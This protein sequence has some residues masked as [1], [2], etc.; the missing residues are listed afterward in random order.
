MG[1][2]L[3]TAAA[4]DQHA[5]DLAR[6]AAGNHFR[7]RRLLRRD[8][9]TP[10]PADAGS[11]VAIRHA[12]PHDVPALERLSQL[13]LRPVLRGDALVAEVDGEVRA[14]LSLDD[15][16]ALADPFLPTAPL[17]TLLTLRAEQLGAA[18]G[19]RSSGRMAPRAATANL[20]RAH[21]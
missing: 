4:A 1:P 15:G 7:P 10:A 9:L 16:R 12:G 8:R 2:S 17:V 19:R 13:E 18:S 3:L 6:S 21:V 14:A 11:T 5:L 20:G